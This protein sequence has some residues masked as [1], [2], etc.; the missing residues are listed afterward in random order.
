MMRRLIF[1]FSLKYNPIENVA[2]FMGWKLIN[3]SRFLLLGEEVS[4]ERITEKL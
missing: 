1:L 4:E 2:Q 3:L